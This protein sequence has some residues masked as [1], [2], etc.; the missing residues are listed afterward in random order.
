[1]EEEAYRRTRKD[2]A[3]GMDGV[4][5][6]A[7]ERRL[8]ENLSDRL[9]RFKGGRYRAPPVRRVHIPKDEAKNTTRPIGIPTLLRH[10]RQRTSTFAPAL[11]GTATLAQVAQSPLACQAAGLA[12]V[13]SSA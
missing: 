5:V 6:E 7:C 4:T 8:H 2:R 11:R 10:H 1:M 3:V 12:D 13:Q 9:E